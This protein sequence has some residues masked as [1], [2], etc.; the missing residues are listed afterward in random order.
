[1]NKFAYFWSFNKGYYYRLLLLFLLQFNLIFLTYAKSSFGT[2]SKQS[3]LL[4]H[5]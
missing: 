3:S 1:M 4:L 5:S 2:N